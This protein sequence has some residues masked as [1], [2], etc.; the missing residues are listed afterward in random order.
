MGGRYFAV[1]AIHGYI[2]TAELFIEGILAVDLSEWG[3]IMVQKAQITPRHG[4]L[5]D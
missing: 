1:S 2:R 3:E 4:F 5:G